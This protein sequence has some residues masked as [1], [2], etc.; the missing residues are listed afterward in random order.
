M[1]ILCLADNEEKE[2]WQG[3]RDEELE[4]LSD[5]DLVLSAGDLDPHYLEFIETMLNV[6]L[7]YVRG[8]HDGRYDEEPPEGCFDIDGM[9]MD[10]KSYRGDVVRI[11]GLGGAIRYG[12]GEDLYTEEE[13]RSRVKKLSRA[14]E[15]KHISDVALCRVGGAF[16]KGAPRKS[17]RKLDIFLTH[18]PSEGHGDMEDMAHRGFSCFNDFLERFRP[19]YHVFGHVHN[20]YGHFRRASV[21][22]CGT[23]L[24]IA[25]GKY[26]IEI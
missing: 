5:T 15:W 16:G 8:N 7:V 25:Y 6:P 19:E 18:S 22:P 21:H 9:V 11:A 2:L 23:K 20:E 10:V 4:K 26:I 14:I 1:K 12:G 24:L 13:M 3:W 17:E